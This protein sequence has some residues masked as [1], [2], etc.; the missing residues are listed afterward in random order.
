M[1][2]GAEGSAR[3]GT[4]RTGRDRHNHPRYTGRQVWSRQRSRPDGGRSTVA[5][6][7]A[8]SHTVSYPGLVSEADFVAVQG[9]RAMRECKDGATRRY[10]L[11]GLVQCRLCVP[12]GARLDAVLCCGTCS[13]PLT[14]ADAD[15]AEPASAGRRGNALAAR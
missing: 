3:S 1:P 11:A 9:L 8:V 12:C 5:G 10:V 14:L 13:D 6:E 4:D 15:L 7:W 2:L